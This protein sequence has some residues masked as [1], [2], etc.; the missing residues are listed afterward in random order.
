MWPGSEMTIADLFFLYSFDLACTV[1]QKLFDIDL[2]AE[3][4]QGAALLELLAQNP[5]VQ[6]GCC[7]SRCRDGCVYGGD[8]GS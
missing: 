8:S 6:P 3:L 7:R 2:K 4:P 5:N 1:A